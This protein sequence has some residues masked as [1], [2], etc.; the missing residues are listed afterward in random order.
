MRH[1]IT[2]FR[3]SELEARFTGPQDRRSPLILSSFSRFTRANSR[4]EKNFSHVSIGGSRWLS[5]NPR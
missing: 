1:R 4:L 5:G 2:S 3:A